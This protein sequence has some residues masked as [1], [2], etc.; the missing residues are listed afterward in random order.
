[1][2]AKGHKRHNAQKTPA[3]ADFHMRDTL[4]PALL[5]PFLMALVICALAH[6]IVAQE[7]VS[8]PKT[9]LEELERKEKELE[10]LKGQSEKP[11]EQIAPANQ[12]TPK[13]ATLPPALPPVV[14]PPPEPVVRYSSPAL[15]SLPAP[16]PYEVI[17]SMDLANYYYANPTA[18]DQRFRKH[19]I[20]VRGEIV[21]FEKP[22]WKRNYRILLK[23]PIRGTRVICDLLPPE[24]SDAVFTTNH[25]DELVALIGETRVPLAKVGQTV[26]VKGECK[27]F[28]NS[29]VL[30]VGWD[31]HVAR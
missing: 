28:S 23:T 4:K 14:A 11:S 19:K 12:E 7:N 25:G 3:N 16:H 29:V 6:S 1:M 21:G 10:R 17:D 8:V 5:S 22:L 26:V 20:S 9:R 27:G 2:A 15:E 24:K 31:P 18:A 13:P 30:V